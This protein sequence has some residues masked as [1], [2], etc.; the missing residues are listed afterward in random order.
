MQI[1][2]VTI[3]DVFEGRNWRLTSST[4]RRIADWK[5][6]VASVFADTDEVVYSALSVSETGEVRALLRGA[7]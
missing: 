2:D 1:H 7:R 5:I 6:E 3:R 4:G